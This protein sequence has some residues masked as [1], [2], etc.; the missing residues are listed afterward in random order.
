MGP[1]E[2][3]LASA[4]GGSPRTSRRASSRI[5][6]SS[7]RSSQ[8]IA[9]DVRNSTATSSQTPPTLSNNSVSVRTRE[10]GSTRRACG[11]SASPPAQVSR[12][13][14]F[15]AQPHFGGPLT[16]TPGDPTGIRSRAR[17][18][19][20][21][22][23]GRIGARSQHHAADRSSLLRQ[24]PEGRTSRYKTSSADLTGPGTAPQGKPPP[25]A[26]SSLRHLRRSTAAGHAPTMAAGG[27][28]DE[29]VVPFGR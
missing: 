5:A 25:V 8:S 26:L 27:Q 10:Y 18:L 13:R 19:S 17:M 15:R 1:D 12:V 11:R 3:R 21:G 29:S 22:R 16:A 20:S 7:D 2:I 9:A 28:V 4:S 14:I 24:I 23:D 6:G